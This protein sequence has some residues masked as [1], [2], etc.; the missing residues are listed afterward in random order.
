MIKCLFSFERSLSLASWE[1]AGSVRVIICQRQINSLILIVQYEF[2]HLYEVSVHSNRP[3]ALGDRAIFN[4]P[5]DFAVQFMKIILYRRHVQKHA[6]SSLN[7]RKIEVNHFLLWNSK[8]QDIEKLIFHDF[9]IIFCLSSNKWAKNR[10][11]LQKMGDERNCS[12]FSLHSNITG[13]IGYI[14]FRSYEAQYAS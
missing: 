3:M 5:S 9:S 10:S 11:S 8:L 6:L 4:Y 13:K 14:P 12:I 1:N 7:K 2:R